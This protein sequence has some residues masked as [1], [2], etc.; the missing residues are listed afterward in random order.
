MDERRDANPSANIIEFEQFNLVGLLT[1]TYIMR[2]NEVIADCLRKVSKILDLALEL[3]Y[4][5]ALF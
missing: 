1:H 2:L 5:H 3:L 4:Y